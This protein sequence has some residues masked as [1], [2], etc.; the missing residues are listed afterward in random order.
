MV[1]INV[2]KQVI[3]SNILAFETFIGP[4]VDI[5]NVHSYMALPMDYKYPM[6]HDYL[7]SG[8]ISYQELLLTVL[9]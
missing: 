8:V 4:Y 9:Y 5:P 3:E 7:A 2:I 6:V 1:D